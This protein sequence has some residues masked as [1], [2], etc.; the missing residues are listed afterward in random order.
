MVFEPL[1]AD[2]HEELADAKLSGD[3]WKIL[4]INVRYSVAFIS[5]MLQKSPLGDLVDFVGKFAK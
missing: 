2:W 1:R 3:V 5:S 4:V